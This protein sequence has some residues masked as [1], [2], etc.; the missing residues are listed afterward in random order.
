MTMEKPLTHISQHMG[1]LTTGHLDV[2]WVAFW[3]ERS[4]PFATVSQCNTLFCGTTSGPRR[5]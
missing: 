3:H 1:K 5:P 4:S 2:I